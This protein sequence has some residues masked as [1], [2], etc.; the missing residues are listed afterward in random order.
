MK[1]LIIED[2]E[3]A[4]RRLHKLIREIA[5]EIEVIGQLDSIEAV[6][7]WIRENKLP[8]LIFM[9][10][11]LADGSSF[12]IFNHAKVDK[13]IIFTTAY[14]Q[15]AIDAFKVNSVDYLLKPIKRQGLEQAIQKYHKWHG[16]AGMDYEQLARAIQG[17]QYNKRFLIRIGQSIRVVEMKDA[18]YF[19]TEN[20]IT[21]VATKEGKRYP[22]D[23]S[24]EKIE[25]LLDPQ[26]FFRINRQFIIGIDAIREMYAYSKSRVKITLQPHCE[27]ETVVSTERSP[28]FKKWLLGESD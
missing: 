2:E 12:E 21:F 3:A 7:N 10:I 27:L 1:V 25:E 17:E 20:K 6:L 11:H 15:Y 13:P 8:D 26:V 24:L 16:K 28:H 23:Q 22:L 18:A 5:P 9:D 19:Y 4:A 14:D